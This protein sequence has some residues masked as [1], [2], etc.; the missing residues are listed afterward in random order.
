MKKSVLMGIALTLVALGTATS[1]KSEQEKVPAIDLTNLDTSVKPGDDFYAYATDGWKRKNPLKPEFSRYGAF[2]VLAENNQIRLNEL[3]QS[4][5]K[6][7]TKPGSVEQKIADLYNMGLDS[8]KLNEQGIA[9]V[10]PAIQALESVADLES[11]AIASAECDMNGVGSIYGG[12]VSTDLIDSN[13]QIFYMSESG[14]AMGNRDYYLLPEH[15][16]LRKGY[17]DFLV[18][19]FGLAGFENAEEM[20]TDAYDVEMAIAVPYWSMV[21]QRD[22]MASYNPMS[23]E[24]MF[25]AYPNLHLDSYCQTLGV[26]AQEKLVVEQPSYFKAINDYVASVD[27]KV[28]RH[29][30]QARVLRDAC[31]AVSDEFYAASFDFF[32]RQMAGVQEQKP[33]W[34]RAM[35]VP[36]GLLGEAVG[37]MYVAKYFPKEDKERMLQIVKNIQ[38]SLSEHIAALDWMS[39]ATKAKAQE[40][41]ANFTIKIG[42]PDKWKDYSTLE[43]DPSKSYYENLVA[44]S[45][46]YTADNLSKLGQPVD[47]EEWLMSPQTVNAYYNPTTNEICFP[48]GILQPPFFNTNADDAVNYGAIG[49]VISH[50]MTHGFD[51][52]GRLF[53]KDGNMNNWW[54]EEDA[55]AFE[56]KT[57]KLVEQFDQVEVLPD[58]FANG[59]ATLGEN[60]ADQGGLRIAFTAMQNSFGGNHPEPI[61]GF[62]AEQRFYLGY[63]AVWAQNITKE[64]M[65]RRVLIDVH[66][67]GEHRVNVSLRN[68]SDF[69]EAFGIKEGDKMFRPEEERVI[70]W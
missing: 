40:K 15:E 65:Q 6:L 23:S 61:D 51:D 7:K 70:I 58:V 62:T 34:K 47:R 18:K 33:R 13:M 54:T 43:I 24:E 11:F 31:G 38:A 9:P 22:I 42:Y 45:R 10:L 1:C 63:A 8:L 52:Q 3:F 21:Q 14:L 27:P 50:E 37:Q 66:S 41:L 67:L 68:I 39:E 57:A 35:A 60:I 16:A 49:V 25:A 4:L 53:D 69:F 56:Q 48:A 5:A 12:G 20:A 64:E 19:V 29:Y 36:N 59:S 26:P 55:K 17:K 28:L 44:A 2:D 46:W 32:S 30:L